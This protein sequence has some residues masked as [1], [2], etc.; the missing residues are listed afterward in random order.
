MRKKNEMLHVIVGGDCSKLREDVVGWVKDACVKR[1]IIVMIELLSH[2]QAHGMTA[3][4]QERE[5]GIL[6]P[7]IAIGGD[8]TMIAA[9]KYGGGRPVIGVKTGTLGYLTEIEAS[10]RAID[11]AVAALHKGEYYT[12]H[13]TTLGYNIWRKNKKIGEGW[14]VNDIV[15]A[16]DNAVA[17]IVF[18]ATYKG[19]FLRR[20]SA[21]GMVIA[22]P[23]GAS[24]YA[25]SCGAPIIEPTSDIICMSPIA[26][27]SLVNRSM[28]FNGNALIE[29][30]V[31]RCR[32]SDVRTV[33][34]VD[35]HIEYDL[36]E[37]DS[38][39]VFKG[40]IEVSKITFSAELAYQR[41]AKLLG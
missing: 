34:G 36:E 40:D 23:I 28:V 22:S 21:D 5:D 33:V 32:N 4:A 8:G 14:A 3:F 29:L 6:R 24:A 16:R 7:I 15:L 20:Y 2:V 10:K 9:M 25:L 18:D 31:R 1:R 30:F 17:N 37:G 11:S 41:L 26:P 38:V 19:M 27:H 13:Y 35:G 12:Q 39:R